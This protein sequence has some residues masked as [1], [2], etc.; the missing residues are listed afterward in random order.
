M[1]SGSTMNESRGI[2][3]VNKAFFGSAVPERPFCIVPVAAGSR[4]GSP[5]KQQDDGFVARTARCKKKSSL[6]GAAG[7]APLRRGPARDACSDQDL[8]VDGHGLFNPGDLTRAG[9]IEFDQNHDFEQYRSRI[10]G[11]V[12]SFV[13]NVVLVKM[14]WYCKFCDA[15]LM[16]QRD[17]NLYRNLEHGV[18][19]RA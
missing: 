3:L 18:G 19:K 15:S 11:R 5:A 4:F 6:S 17:F 7:K 9:W 16:D 13:A 10:G 8:S 12:F 14:Y 2:R 1:E